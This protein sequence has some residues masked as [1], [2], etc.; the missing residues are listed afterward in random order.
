[1]KKNVISLLTLIFLL[2]VFAYQGK[3]LDKWGQNQIIQN[4][5]ISYY[6]YL[7]AAI[8]FN[9]LNFDFTKKLPSDF[10]GKIWLQTAP[11]GKPILRMTM[12]LA[13]LWLP[14]FLLAH[15]FAHLAGISALGYSWP[16]SLSIF[17]AALFYFAVG[18]W[19]LIR[20]AGRYFSDQAIAV[21][22]L[23]LALATNLNFYMVSEPGM[24]HVFNFALI[25]AFLY[26]SISWTEF[27]TVKRTLLMGF[28]AGLIVLIRPVNILVLIFPALYGISK[29]SEIVDRITTNWKLIMLAGVMAFLTLF[30]QF[31]YWKAQTGHFLFNSYM[32]Q[33]K[34]YFLKPQIINGLF[35]YRKGWLIYSPVMITSLVGF[36]WLL[37]EKNKLFFPLLLF[38]AVNIYVVFSWWCW[39]YG[40]SFGSRP[41]I[42]MYGLLA[43]PMAAAIERVVNSKFWIRGIAVAVFSAL[44]FLNQFQMKQYQ[45][46]LLHWDS[47]SRKAYWGIMF[48]EQWPEN[49]PEMIKIPDYDKALKGEKE[50][51]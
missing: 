16:Y 3:K 9:D 2:L 19:Y 17:L 43:I 24:S 41:M 21:T 13:I 30:P 48:K 12:G 51:P 5:V 7:P 47:M 29:P 32:D 22:L 20:M 18:C 34:F 49:Y 42:D 31:L 44:I 45:T 40:G 23:L 25:A 10:E 27:P 26:H 4:D 39:W 46:S 15:A 11:N 28:L 14:F 33:G 50:Y 8:I 35:S 37:R 1:M 36:F 6:A 38:V